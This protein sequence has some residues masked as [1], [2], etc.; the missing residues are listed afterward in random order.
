MR[1][2]VGRR[3][4]LRF[5]FAALVLAASLPSVAA[6]DT[7]ATELIP[8]TAVLL[9]QTSS[10]QQQSTSSS[11]NIFSPPTYV[12]IK[13]RGGEPTVAIDRYPFLPGPF[14][15]GATSQ[16]YKDLTYVSA[17]EG[18][19]FPGYS[20][21]W[22][23][24]DQGQT[25]RVPP[26]DPYF[27]RP[28][29]TN[30]GGDSHQAVG[31]TT[32][33]VFFLDLPGLCVDMNVSRDLG[34][35]FTTDDLGCGANP[36]AID[37]RQ[38][39]DADESFPGAAAKTVGATPIPAVPAGS[40]SCLSG[41]VPSC[42]NVYVSF[43]NF[44]TQV[45]PTLALA[46]STHD[47]A[48]GTFVTDS[49]C[50]ELTQAATGQPV[51]PSPTGPAA[52]NA[53]TV[54]PD[55]TDNRLMD[56]GPVVVD[57]YVTH[58]VYIPFIR[59]TFDAQSAGAVAPYSIWVAKSTDGG[60]TWTRYK[61]AD[62]GVRYPGN[63]FQQMTVDKAGNLYSAFILAQ[64]ASSNADF[65]GE[66]D[67]YYSYS[68][69]RGATWAPPVDI[70]PEN[71][72]SVVFPWIVAGDAGE[73]DYVFYKSN[74][75]LNPN[76]AAVDANGKASSC[77]PDGSSCFDNPSVWNVYFSQSQN[78]LNSGANFKTVQISERPNHYGQICT[79]GLNCDLLAGGNRNL[80]DFFT[81]DVDHLGAAIVS[82]TEDNNGRNDTRVVNG[83]QI[84]GNSVF[85]NTSISLQQ[86]WPIYDHAVH[87]Q[88]GDVF[89]ADGAPA[90]GCP[91]EDILA[92]SV[93][94]SNDI[95]TASLTLNAPPT[96]ATAITC[97]GAQATGGLWGIAFWA[98]ADPSPATQGGRNGNFYLAYRDN[99]GDVGA[100]APG[101]EAGGVNGLEANF[102]SNEFARTQTGTLGG[103]C[104][105]AAG[106]P[107]PTAPTPCTITMSTAMSTL[108]IK[109]GASLLSITGF[110][111]Y[112]F[113]SEQFA[114]LTRLNLGFSQLADLT[115]ALD[116]NGTGTTK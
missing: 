92:A 71:G 23:S 94:R 13:R 90:P 59:G 88:P 47:G 62:T 3:R 79:S 86:S 39:V 25:Y 114:P 10:G 109:S 35:T 40:P 83:R 76:V 91:S 29:A 48:P 38:W 19:A 110:S 74:T 107:N 66:T 77:T 21:F 55:P 18:V 108:G 61:V 68:T 64:G 31:S 6:G 112:M 105:T 34:E 16:S 30:G 57:R 7:G 81:V 28:S 115:A 101:V 46:R 103:T 104:L 102:T 33:S 24:S 44:S 53:P 100:P 99:P 5:A 98:P 42:G 41:P 58:N 95:L 14:A 15:F 80:S 20:V 85:K 37:D 65:G 9:N 45:A 67:A 2:F 89:N 26:H 78:A 113:G 106:Q 70:T 82:W 87:D 72:D 52:D 111:A 50:N 54:C 51:N 93:S 27:G 8:G 97:S 32:H 22:K 11:T 84:S 116:D 96:A 36:G 43:I 1:K 56:A 60:S 49:L 73:V 75:G 17:P 63:I 69:D 4:A 12:D